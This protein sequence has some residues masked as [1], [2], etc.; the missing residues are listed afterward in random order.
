MWEPAGEYFHIR[1]GPR[2][3]TH[4][5]SLFALP[6]YNLSASSVCAQCKNVIMVKFTDLASHKIMVITIKICI[7]NNI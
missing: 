1:P 2:G 5:F 3:V 6:R 4:Q 7:T